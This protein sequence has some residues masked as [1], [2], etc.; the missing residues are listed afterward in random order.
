M[1]ILSREL[2]IQIMQTDPTTA[3]PNRE[4]NSVSEV[5]LANEAWLDEAIDQAVEEQLIQDISINQFMD[6]GIEVFEV[7][8]VKIGNNLVNIG[9]T[10]IP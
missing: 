5:S 10:Y 2:D 9:I 4:T 8:S 1:S 6:E 3:R 7:F